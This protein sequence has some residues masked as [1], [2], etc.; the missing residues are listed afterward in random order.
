MIL[1]VGLPGW[2][3]YELACN[4]KAWRATDGGGDGGGGGGGGGSRREGR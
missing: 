1:E 3:R 2:D 4:S